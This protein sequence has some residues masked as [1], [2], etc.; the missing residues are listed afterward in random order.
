[1]AR[2]VQMDYFSLS[3]HALDISVRRPQE[4]RCRKGAFGEMRH[5][6]MM[7]KWRNIIRV[8]G[9]DHFF[10]RIDVGDSVDQIETGAFSP[11][12]TSKTKLVQYTPVT[13]DG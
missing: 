12:L 2:I 6:R 11:G 4:D 10:F 13:R 1:M 5:T 9:E 7:G 8:R 3:K